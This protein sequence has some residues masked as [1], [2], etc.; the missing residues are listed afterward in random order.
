LRSGAK[1][2]LLMAADNQQPLDLIL[3]RNLMTVLETPSFLTDN[4]AQIVFFNDAAGDLLGKRFEETG[5]L[6]RDEW[7]AI[8]PVN[9][10]GEPVPHHKMPLA[11]ALREGRPAHGRFN[12]RTDAGRILEVATSAVPLVSAG[13]FHGALVLFWPVEGLE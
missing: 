7:N 12:I 5:R 13:D 9:S 8:G 11:V 3:A 1:I 10:E 2:R 6:S 4:D